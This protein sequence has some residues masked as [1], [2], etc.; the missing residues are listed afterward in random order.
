[1][2]IFNAGRDS[3]RVIDRGFEFFFRSRSNLFSHN[4]NFYPKRRI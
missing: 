1:L 4:L 3:G 2:L